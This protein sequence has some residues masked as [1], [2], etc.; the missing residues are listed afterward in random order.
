MDMLLQLGL[1]TRLVGCLTSGPTRNSVSTAMTTS[2]VELL[3]LHSVNPVV[4]YLLDMMTS[5]ATFGTHS[6][7]KEQ[8]TVDIYLSKYILHIKIN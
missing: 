1:M 2:S 6:E 3:V 4:F 8:V 5:T 7:L